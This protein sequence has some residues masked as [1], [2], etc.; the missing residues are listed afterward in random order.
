[1]LT[2]LIYD[3]ELS[4]GRA[5][6]VLMLHKTTV[7]HCICDIRLLRPSEKKVAGFLNYLVLHI[8]VRQS[9]TSPT[10]IHLEARHA[11]KV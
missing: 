1:M 6:I 9:R 4:V 8:H 7:I 3:I 10:N 2:F 11:G 5:L